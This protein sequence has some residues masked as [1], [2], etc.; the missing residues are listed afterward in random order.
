MR[1][2]VWLPVLAACWFLAAVL[3]PAGTANASGEGCAD[4]AL[5]GA[6]VTASVRLEHG[7]RTHTKITTELRVDVPGDWEH[8]GDLLLG[9]D[10]RAYVTAMACLTRRDGD[11]A[12][13]WS[14]RRPAPPAVTSK[15]SRVRIVDRAYSWVDQYRTPVRVGVWEL[16]AGAD[17]WTVSLRPPT[18]LRT[19][20]W[21]RITVDPGTPGAHSA[22]PRPV[23]KEG[24]SALVWR[25]TAAKEPGPGAKDTTRE[26]GAG[27]RQDERQDERR[28]RP[29]PAVP[30]VTVS[31]EPSWQ[32][33]WA[34]QN[35]R[36]TAAGLDTLGALLWTSTISGLL[37][38]AVLLYRRRPAAPTAVQRRTLRNLAEWAVVSVALFTLVH[39]DDLIRR[40]DQRRSQWWLDEYVLRGHLFALAAAALLFCVA[41][42]PRR[43]WAAG[44]VLGVPPLA[45][46]MWP[47]AFGL[48]PS[49]LREY[50]ASGT[51]IAAEVTASWCLAALTA[52]GCVSALWRLADDAGLLPPGR[53][54]P[55]RRRRLRL[56]VAGPVVVAWT[57][58]LACS[59]ALT[60][61][62]NW[63]RASWLMDRW[64]DQYGI[65]HRNDFVWEAM[66]STFT[67][68]ERILDHAWLLT[69]V[70]VLAVL[71]TWHAPTPASAV[72][73]LTHRPVDPADRLLLLTFFPLA[74]GLDS[75][76]HLADALAVPLWIPLYMLSLWAAV[77]F[78]ARTA[79]LAQPFAVSGEPL[80]TRTGPAARAF[81]LEG[82]RTYRETH[83]DLRRLDQGFFGDQPP[84]RKEREGE[85]DALHDWPSHGALTG[86]PAERLPPKVSVVDAALA[87]GPRDHWWANGVR[88]ARCALLPGVPAAALGVWADRVRAEAWQD[89]LTD[90]FGLPGMLLALLYWLSTWVGA[91]FLLGAL[92]RVLPGRRGAVKALPVAA[93]FALPV[94]LD[95]L[96]GRFTQEG[97]ANFALYAST[98]LL[99]LTVT[100]IAIDLDTFHGERRYWQSRL[101][102][103][104]SVYQMRY[105]SLQVA[106][107]VAQIIAVITIWQF[108]TEP[109]SAPQPA[110]K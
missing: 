45:T 15:G 99:V 21:T 14:Q 79:V 104:L 63:Q 17:L 57:V 96:A 19:A 39:A 100:A 93:A 9:K 101:G 25:P 10:S 80:V 67:T 22:T 13:R 43:W 53:R 103:L 3:A 81:L 58:A 30:S 16:R 7:G 47:Q 59:H 1:R 18:A 107:L 87:L 71:R 54:L 108:F 102:L 70:A 88:G 55:G 29:A 23:A 61:E 52:F 69:V 84:V 60:E 92:W 5:A 2:S 51:A 110:G 26:N 109:S 40:Y 34:A 4:A 72:T 44:A 68:P 24:A 20:R 86:P 8:A 41:R 46:M 27:R 50:E 48:R 82:S 95:A 31:L 89:T 85:L 91:G 37:L 32:R 11:D 6:T 105:Y 42:P 56:R 94:G 33:S 106:Y 78:F 12:L 62:R 74:V 66:W 97:S 75:G 36:L 90:P 38:G 28:A 98:M 77:T 35:D 73:S 76:Y 64:D 49:R 83:A 65:D